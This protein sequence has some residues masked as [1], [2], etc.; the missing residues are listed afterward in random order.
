MNQQRTIP[1]GFPGRFFPHAVEDEQTRLRIAQ[2]ALAG[3]SVTSL[4]AEYDI[5]VRTVMRYRDAL[6][7]GEN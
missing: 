2:R 3:E 6:G 7:G 5:S 4:A 1:P